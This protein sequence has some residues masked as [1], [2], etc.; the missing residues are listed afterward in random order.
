LKDHLIKGYTLNQKRLAEK[1]LNEA[2]Q[3]I[4]TLRQDLMAR[5]V[6]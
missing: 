1:G 3:A 5:G 6:D 4:A 2:R